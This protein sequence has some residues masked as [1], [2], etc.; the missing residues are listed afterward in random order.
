MKKL[1]L[2]LIVCALSVFAGRA[3]TVTLNI[4]HPEYVDA[5]YYGPN[6]SVVLDLVAGDNP[7]SFETSTTVNIS[8][9]YG[10]DF[11]SATCNGEPVNAPG[12]FY[13]TVDSSTNGNTYVITTATQESLRTAHLTLKCD[14][15]TMVSLTFSGTGYSPTLV[16]NEQV[17][18]FNPNKETNVNLNSKGSRSLYKVTHNGEDVTGYY[19]S[20]YVEGVADNDV[21]EVEANYPVSPQPVKFEI[22]EGSEG[23][24]SWVL[25]DGTQVSNF[26][27]D[28]FTVNSGSTLKLGI[29][30][31]LFDN[32][33]LYV[34][35]VIQNYV[36][37]GWEMTVN[38]PVT[39]KL[40]GTKKATNDVVVYI[41]NANAVNVY[42]SSHN[43]LT[44]NSG[45]NNFQWANYTYMSFEAKEGYAIVKLERISENGETATEYSSLR[46]ASISYQSTYGACTYKL[47]TGS[48]DDLRTAS[49]TVT[50]DDPSKV[51]FSVGGDL[52]TLQAGTNTIK[53]VPGVETNVQ[54][55]PNG[56]S[57]LASVTYNGTELTANYGY[58]NIDGLTDGA[59]IDIKAEFAVGNAKVKVT[60]VDEASKGYI[61]GINVN[62]STPLTGFDTEE[63]AEVAYGSP[64]TI[65]GNADMKLESIALNGTDITSSFYGYYNT[66][67]SSDMDILVKAHPY[68]NVIVTVNVDSAACV[69]ASYTDANYQAHSIV[70][71]NGANAVEVPENLQYIS[72]TKADEYTITSFKVDGVET[73]VDY[74]GSW[75]IYSPAG[76][77]I[78]IT[79]KEIIRDHKGMLYMQYAQFSY[80]SI[81]NEN[82]YRI[83]DLNGGTGVGYKPFYFDAND[84]PFRIAGRGSEGEIPYV[85]VN[86]KQIYSNSSYVFNYDEYTF[87]DGDVVKVFVYEPAT[88][89]VTISDPDSCAAVTTDRITPVA[90]YASIN[91]FATTEVGISAREGDKIESVTLDGHPL[92]PK[93]DGS[94]AFTVAL[95]HNVVIT[96]DMTGIAGIA[97]DSASDDVY[98][99]QGIKMADTDHL[100]PGI[101]IKGG[102]KF[103]VK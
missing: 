101:Y 56:V 89:T 44:V 38:E 53:F 50:V 96:K 90:D 23:I 17:I 4:D 75:M 25:V 2:L 98:N 94:Y 87:A 30:S 62:Y 68:G 32:I 8:A 65:N 69:S 77:V 79:S 80:F 1:Y 18:S 11:A 57:A 7:L 64:I 43:L 48:L 92:T 33:N 40:S 14:D 24:L 63:G 36:Y 19:G 49:A 74:N 71:E 16:S 93:A 26:M 72:F 97:T 3:A 58:Y 20:F 88:K 46:N 102:K 15:Y 86:G 54:I 66:T 91:V 60:Y 84:N 78:D 61:T 59:T 52:R 41:D 5:Y 21:I 29:N 34:N 45:N 12:Y 28:N 83:V 27:D 103:I 22:A 13:F 47:T 95:N 10:Y 82:R 85:F 55:S 100:A 37:S 70:L 99:L 73:A 31:D 35:D 67:V 42:D 81:E 6:G 9:K 51:Y 76:K 39:L